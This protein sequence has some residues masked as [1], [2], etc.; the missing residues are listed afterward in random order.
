[1]GI[2]P[3][4]IENELAK[5]AEFE[6]LKNMSCSDKNFQ[7]IQKWSQWLVKYKFGCYPSVSDRKGI[8]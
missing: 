6:K 8:D 5:A 2:T 3:Q 1:M 4:Y 7:D